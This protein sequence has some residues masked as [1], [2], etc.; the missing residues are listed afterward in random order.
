[1]QK[2]PPSRLESY[3]HDFASD[4]VRQSVSIRWIAVLEGGKWL[5][6]GL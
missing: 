5:L 2:L 3:Q 4:G 6:T 1:V